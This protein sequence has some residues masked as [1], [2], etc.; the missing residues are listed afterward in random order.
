MR[1]GDQF[2]DLMD[3]LALSSALGRTDEILAWFDARVAANEL[4]VPQMDR[5]MSALLERGQLV[6]WLAFATPLDAVR[7]LLESVGD[8][9]ETLADFSELLESQLVENDCEVALWRRVAERARPSELA[10]IDAAIEASERSGF[11]RS[12]LATPMSEL[13]EALLKRRLP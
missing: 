10:A 8:M 12:W 6:D 5:L 4:P 11:I 9:Q 13:T 1:Q 2:P 7:E 3:W